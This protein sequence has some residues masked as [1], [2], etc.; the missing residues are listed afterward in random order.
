MRARTDTPAWLA[1]IAGLWR[2]RR[3]AA[4]VEMALVS[5]VLV[6]I[7]AATVDLG[8][9]LY[10]RFQLTSAV[11]AATN[12]AIVNV[13][14]V[15]SS[16]GPTLATNLATLAANVNGTAWANSSVT[17]N[18]GPTA[19]NTSGTAASG[20]TASAAN[21]CYCPTGSAPSITWGTAQSC[22]N[23]CSGSGYAGMFVLVTASRTYTPFFSKYGIINNGAISVSSLVQVQ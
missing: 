12:Y 20:G 6:L 21:S 15:N 16:S 22:G 19:S 17:V 7:L 4:A 13:A 14:S 5:P 2:D 23:P 8:G 18:G 11:N 9:V 1:R 3:G 10:T